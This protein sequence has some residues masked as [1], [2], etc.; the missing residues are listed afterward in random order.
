MYLFK[1]KWNKNQQQLGRPFII[2]Q[3]LNH[4]NLILNIHW[5]MLVKV[6][7][8]NVSQEENQALYQLLKF[9]NYHKF[10]RFE[11]TTKNQQ[12]LAKVEIHPHK[13]LIHKIHQ[14]KLII[15]QKD[16]WP[17]IWTKIKKFIWRELDILITNLIKAET[18]PR[19]SWVE[20]L[21]TLML[22]LTRN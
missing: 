9:V 7:E 20:L 3:C 10:L 5:H 8:K 17:N 4:A 11:H 16:N 12:L 1:I 2:Y 13:Q 22:S 19:F 6:L 21:I 15:Q 14:Q 18:K